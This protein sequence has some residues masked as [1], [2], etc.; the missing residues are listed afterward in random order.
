MTETTTDIKDGHYALGKAYLN[1]KQYAEAITHFQTVLDIDADFIEAHCGLCRAYLAQNDYEN[2]ET[3]VLMARQLAPNA[4]EVLSLCGA[5][6][7]T[8]YHKGITCYNEERYREAVDYFQKTM[9]FDATYIA[10]YH[11]QA[12][13]YFGL[14]ELA[15]AKKAAQAALR[16]DPN[17]SPVLSFLKTIEPSLPEPEPATTPPVVADETKAMLPSVEPEKS[18]QETQ[19]IADEAAEFSHEKAMQRALV[20]LNNRQYLQ[21]EAG[22]KKIIEANPNDVEPHYHLAQT[23]MEIGAFSDAQRHVDIALRMRPT[24]QP[25][26]QL[27]NAI[28]LLKKREKNR[29]RNKKIR[30][31]LLPLAVLAIAGVIAFRAGVFNYFLPKSMPPKVSIEIT[32]EDPMNKNGI[33]DAGENVRLKLLITN[34]GST[35]KNLSVRMLP[36]TIGGLRY[37]LP[38]T[39]FSVRKNGFQTRRIPITADKQVRTRNVDMKVQVLEINEIL[40]TR[41]FQF[42][43]KGMREIQ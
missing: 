19:E 4:P 36:K 41:D 30:K 20:F 24:Y 31:I 3:A 18:S 35:A 26:L 14:H 8:Y 42:K 15:A 25:V 1:N 10:A 5:L 40:A 28:T 34:A 39:T 7:E 27:Q 22:F 38:K 32:L 16:I 9:T 11:A 12:L 23:Y 17:Y 43:I 2:A 6:K 37:Q 29:Q 21:A 13:A 33:I